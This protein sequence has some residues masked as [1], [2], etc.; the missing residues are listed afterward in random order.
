MLRSFLIVGCTPASDT[1]QAEN[2]VA[3]IKETK[4][5]SSSKD[6]FRTNVAFSII[7]FIIVSDMLLV[8]VQGIR[9]D[10]LTLIAFG[11]VAS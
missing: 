11:A 8:L 1:F 7:L 10:E 3:A 5:K 2:V 4:L 6:V 9:M